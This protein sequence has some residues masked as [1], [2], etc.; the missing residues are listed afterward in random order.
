MAAA[1]TVLTAQTVDLNH[2]HFLSALCTCLENTAVY[3]FIL[4]FILFHF[5]LARNR[6]EYLNECYQLDDM[7]CDFT[8]VGHV[9]KMGAAGTM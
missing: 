8:Y 6:Y 7:V 5:I 3:I 2:R 9:T 1:A 4:F